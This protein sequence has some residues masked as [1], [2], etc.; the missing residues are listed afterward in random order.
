MHSLARFE[1]EPV[2]SVVAHRQDPVCI[3][4][5]PDHAHHAGDAVQVGSGDRIDR[6]LHAVLHL[7]IQCGFDQVAVTRH[8]FFGDPGPRQILQGVVAEEGTIAGGNAA[9]RQRVRLRQNA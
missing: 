2:T 8:I 5:R 4:A 3:F 7:R 1:F 6:L 9:L